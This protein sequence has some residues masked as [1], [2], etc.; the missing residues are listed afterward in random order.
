MVLKGPQQDYRV[1]GYVFV[2]NG[3]PQNVPAS[4]MCYLMGLTNSGAAIFERVPDV[5]DRD[6]EPLIRTTPKVEVQEKKVEM[7][8]EVPVETM[9]VTYEFP[10]VVTEETLSKMLKNDLVEMARVKYGI[11]VPGKELKAVVI[12]AILEAEAKKAD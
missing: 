5:E 11:D 7:D 12:S 3:E 1:Q 2:R 4:L 9:K 6:A 10:S 8:T